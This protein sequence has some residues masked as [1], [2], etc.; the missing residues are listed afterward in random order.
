MRTTACATVV[1]LLTLAACDDGDS[2]TPQPRDADVDAGHAPTAPVNP[3]AAARAFK[4]YYKERVHRVMRAYHRF[5][6]FGDSV[7][8]TTNGRVA[9][10]KQGTDY[11]VVVGFHP[12]S[13]IGTPVFATYYAYKIFR[14]RE[15]E[16]SL[17]RML[18]GLVFYEEISGHPGMTAREVLP[19]WTRVMDG[20][21]G[22]V[23]RHRLGT[24][25]TPPALAAR[26]RDLER[27]YL[28][29]FY[30]GIRVTYREN[31]EDYFFTYFPAAD[32]ADY[33][34]TYSFPEFPRYLRMFECCETFMRTPDE[35]KWGGAYWGNHNSRDNLPDF[36]LG[37]VA[38][39]L[40]AD[41]EGA[42]GAVREAARRAVTAGQ[43][44]GDAILE[45]G[46]AMMTVGEFTPY[47]EL[48][49]S[50]AVRPHGVAENEDLGTL[51][52]CP[53][54]YLVRA[55]SSDG[56]SLPVPELPV[57]GAVD[58]ERMIREGAVDCPADAT[59]TCKRLDDGFCGL[60]WNKTRSLTVAGQPALDFIETLEAAMPGTAER[61]LGRF[62]DDYDDIV[63]AMV[64]IVHY[65]VAT[66]D[67]ELI[68]AARKTEKDMSNV[69]RDFAEL[70]WGRTNP[71]RATAQRYAAAT[72]DALAG[73]DVTLT[74]TADF[75][76]EEAGIT[77]VEALLDMEDTKAAPLKT[78]TEIREEVESAVTSLEEEMH[79]SGRGQI[80]VERY[81]DAWGA[82]PPVRRVGNGYEARHTNGDW[83][84]AEVPRHVDVNNL[85]LLQALPICVIS[86]HVLDCSWAKLGCER[87]DLDR[88]GDVDDED[89]KRFDAGYDEG[90]RCGGNRCDG[91]DLDASGKLDDLDAAFMRAALGCRYE[92]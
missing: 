59:P 1:V 84:P 71:E 77:R 68:E 61:L 91:L 17:L 46:G 18:E 12:N 51:A 65:A 26:N 69:M 70:I 28:D 56:L 35:F 87:P 31:P 37:F 3:E 13:L 29:T 78:D 39:T 40:A 27:E 55:L 83:A 23:T 16:L 36:S 63:E 47:D 90:R 19:A 85:E 50:G 66:G 67:G 42:S 38:A 2:A 8:G 86:P 53:D 54:A 21:A 58:V 6:T 80:I 33:A 92:R 74:D 24:P 22:K 79:A 43:R 62:Q 5:G 88:D 30:A 60:P 48:V 41:D 45:N 32:T 25:F 9:V 64:A 89:A 10:A 15:L 14:T 44:V 73:S 76:A 81:R 52:N 11:E 72:F 20:V 4:L 75:A 7:F 82:T 57:P 34:I 49:V